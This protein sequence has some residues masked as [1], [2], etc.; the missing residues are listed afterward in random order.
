MNG[1]PLVRTILDTEAV[2][3]WYHPK[4][5]IVHHEFRRFV[6]GQEL[7]NALLKGA[8]LFTHYGA[9]KWLSD[10]RRNGPVRPADEQWALNE[11]FPKV[12]AAGW[13]YWAVVM[14][15]K[16]MGQM[17]MKRWIATYARQEIQAQ[18]FTTPLEALAWLEPL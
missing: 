8:E 7:R 17:N 6:Y 10:D 15:D 11:W 1:R 12:K 16:V 5:K 2:G 9:C 13:K 18:A 4:G 14:P 3:L